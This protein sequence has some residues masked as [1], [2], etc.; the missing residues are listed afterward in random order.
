[1]EFKN[2]LDDHSNVADEAANGSLVYKISICTDECLS[3]LVK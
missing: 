3:Y 1:M 2:K